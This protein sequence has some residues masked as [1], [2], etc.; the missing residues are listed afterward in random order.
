M[1]PKSVT[2]DVDVLL[3]DTIKE[4]KAKIKEVQRT[5]YP[6]LIGDNNMPLETHKLVSDYGLK[7]GDHLRTGEAKHDRYI[8]D[9]RM[10]E[11]KRTQRDFR[12]QI[13]MRF[14]DPTYMMDQT[15]CRQIEVDS[16]RLQRPP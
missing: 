9:T 16:Q 5:T 13:P 3:T 7:N 11:M 12:G 4:V 2:S 10:S 14:H 1:S 15:L 8:T 6:R